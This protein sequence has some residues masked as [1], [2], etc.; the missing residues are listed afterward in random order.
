MRTAALCYSRALAEFDYGDDHPFKPIRARSTLELCHM[1]GLT[2]AVGL[3]Q[4]TPKP[5]ELAEVER[6]H[7]A[8]YI[9]ALRRASAGTL[10]LSNGPLFG[11]GTQDCP[12]LPGIWEFSLLAT[13]ATLECVRLVMD[14][15]VE[16]ALKLVEAQQQG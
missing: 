15:S 3:L 14:G 4:P 8:E 2:H 11:I 6:F 10:D 5:A 1:Y 7:T 13:G 12:A 16:R 9:D